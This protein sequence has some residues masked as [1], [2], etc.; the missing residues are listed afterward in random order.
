AFRDAIVSY[1]F[2]V[3]TKGYD[4]WLIIKIL[5]H[6]FVATRSVGMSRHDLIILDDRPVRPV[7][8][9][10][11]REFRGGSTIVDVANPDGTQNREYRQG[12][13][14]ARQHCCS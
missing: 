2:I 3:L 11:L 6:K 13:K 14:R 8:A 5:D 4:S 7:S 12:R 9:F 10:A 1:M